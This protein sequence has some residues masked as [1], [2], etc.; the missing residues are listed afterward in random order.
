MSFVDIKKK[1]KNE[2]IFIFKTTT[3]FRT[4]ERTSSNDRLLLK[5]KISIF[6]RRDPLCKPRIEADVVHEPQRRAPPLIPR[7]NVQQMAPI[8][9]NEAKCNAAKMDGR[10]LCILGIVDLAQQGPIKRTIKRRLT[11]R[12]LPPSA[13]YG[14]KPSPLP[15]PWPGS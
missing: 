3:F 5:R 6:H 13:T 2:T 9:G 11:P 15:L 7:V 4:F 14:Q 12:A 8:P 1:I 10:H